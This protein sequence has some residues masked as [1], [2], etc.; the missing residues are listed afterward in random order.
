MFTVRGD[1]GFLHN[2]PDR[3][4]FPELLNGLLFYFGVG[5]ALWHWRDLRYGF[6]LIWSL[7]SLIPSVVTVD[8]PGFPRDIL[9]QVVVFVFPALA[10]AWIARRIS[11]IASHS[12][13]ATAVTQKRGASLV[14]QLPLAGLLALPLLWSCLSTVRD[15]FI[16]WPQHEGVRFVYPA[17]L[18]AAAHRVDELGPEK[19]I[20]VAGLSVY[21]VDGPGI[22]LASKSKADRVRLSDTRETLIVPAEAGGRLLVPEV[23]PFASELQGRLLAAGGQ[24]VSQPG[25]PFTEYILPDASAVAKMLQTIPISLPNGTA[26]ALP[27]SFGNQLALVGT[28]WIAKKAAPGGELVLLTAWRVE[29][30]PPRPLRVFVHLLDAQGRVRAQHDGLESPPQGWTPGDL[31]LQQHTMD[32]PADLEAGTYTIEVGLYWPKDGQRLLVAGADRVLL[33]PIKVKVQ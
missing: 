20:V 3:P 29:S 24:K 13:L 21:S 7:G 12:S 31:I 14:Y 26:L 32:L 2:L 19:P 25:V 22:K 8:A 27:A 10:L 6:L 4:V 16:V 33:A 17:A 30:P 15:Y 1:A 18:T 23:V 5:I 28:E 11:S 9:A